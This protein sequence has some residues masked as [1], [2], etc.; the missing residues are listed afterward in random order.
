LYNL[1]KFPG[2][3]LRLHELNEHILLDQSSLSRLVERMELDGL[4][5]RSDDPS[6]RRGTMIELT[7]Y[8]G[9]VQREMGREH[10]N[11]ISSYVGEALTAD[12]LRTLHRLCAKLRLAQQDIS[13]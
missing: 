3:R 11:A 10:A 2:K 5:A 4:V 9:S 1:S 7:E 13:A 6:D 12:E 8:G